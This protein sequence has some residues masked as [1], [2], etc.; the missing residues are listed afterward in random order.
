MSEGDRMNATIQQSMLED[1]LLKSSVLQLTPCN[2]RR[3]E[4]SAVRRL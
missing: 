2:G 4:A 3:T 1:L